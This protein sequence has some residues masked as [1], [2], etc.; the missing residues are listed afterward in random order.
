LAS[1]VAAA[2]EAGEFGFDRG[3]IQEIGV[4][5]FAQLGISLSGPAAPDHEH[6]FNA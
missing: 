4:Q 5:D 6:A 2:S 1:I 3:E